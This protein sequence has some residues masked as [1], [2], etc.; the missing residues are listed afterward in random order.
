MVSPEKIELLKEKI[1]TA[2][3]IVVGGA[4]GMSAA[5]GFVFYYQNDDV[6]RMIAG[7]LEQK[8]GFHNYFDAYY[9]SGHTRG[10]HWAMILRETKYL[11]DCQTGDTYK[12]LAELL[13]DK[14]YYIATT[15]QDA[16]FYR[17]FPKEKITCIQGDSRYWQ[18]SRPCHDEIYF[19]KEQV[20]DLC[21]K[22]RNDSLPEELIPR[23]PSC[24]S[25]MEPWVRGYSFL[26]GSYYQKE[27]KRYMDFLRQ[28]ATR[29]TLYLELGVGM[30]TPMFIKE[31]FM[32]MV[33][34]WPD[35]FY[36]TV[37]PQHAI[38]PKEIANRSI[39]LNDDIAVVLKLLLGKPV[40][41]ISDSTKKEI[42]NPSRI[43]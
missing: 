38:I 12:D 14:N 11:Y 37:N 33:H 10:E 23:C 22:I 42:F 26:Q 5:S 2:D 40:E 4:S 7:S 1:E 30:M 20:L 39:A 15:N 17:V 21:K 43:Y 19:N 31:P 29:K 25:E 27:M 8:Y 6:F 36:A 3:A 24:G 34:Q 9:H 18:C 35:A 13:H 28:N 32:N 41:N 16:Q